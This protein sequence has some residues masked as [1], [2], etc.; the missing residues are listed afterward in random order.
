MAQHVVHRRGVASD[1]LRRHNLS[2]VLER[3]HLATTVSRSALAD[4]TGLNRST[5][6][7]LVV[8][9]AD[10][11]LVI[12]DTGTTTGSPGRPSSIVRARP[13][14]A[15]VLA[16]ELEVDYTGVA[17]V[18]L[19][20][21]ILDRVLAPNPSTSAPP[22]VVVAHL[23]DLATPL[24]D[25]LP[26]AQ[27]IVGVGVAAAGLVRRRDGL[28]STSPNRGWSGVPLGAMIA[29][30]FGIERV[31]VANEADAG[32][33]AEFRR[34]SAHDVDNLVYIS[35][36]VGLGLGIIQ[37]GRP[38][39]GTLGYAGEA[40]HSVI[41]PGGRPCRCGSVGC[42][43]TEV[44]AEALARRAGLAVSDS[45]D[46]LTVEV[47]RRAH[48]GDREVLDALREVGQWLGIGV[49]N[50]INTFNP[51]LIVFGGFYASIYA[52]LEPWIQDTAE[53]SSLAAAWDACVIRRSEL[54]SDARLLG[55]GELVFA[56]V[57]ADPASVALA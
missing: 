27:R 55:A 9:L 22:D 29:E 57:I 38:M 49:G 2:A 14:G 26:R 43:E 56:D 51:D 30:R 17:I 13:T 16:V 25:G 24:L 18:G 36:A 35:G 50:L 39:S 33:L 32:A 8:E 41:N 23:H 34:G 10:L 20:G 7:D 5:I 28:I 4:E 53:R 42:W 47:L 45:R 52:F 46:G 19:G 44:G 31:M 12:E 54:G 11:G 21:R 15:A 6:R 1:G 37:G 48:L 40:G 3:V